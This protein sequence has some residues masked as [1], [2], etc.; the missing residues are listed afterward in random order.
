VSV[1]ELHLGLAGKAGPD[2]VFGGCLMALCTVTGFWQSDLPEPMSAIMLLS[3]LLG[4][5][6]ARQY[7]RLSR[8]GGKLADGSEVGGPRH[9]RSRHAWGSVAAG[10]APPRSAVVASAPHR[11]AD[12]TSENMC[13]ILQSLPCVRPTKDYGQLTNILRRY[14]TAD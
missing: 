5:A 8:G 13:G 1:A 14:L 2:D 9:F 7:L 3:G 4:L 12:V 11:A 6:L 10:L